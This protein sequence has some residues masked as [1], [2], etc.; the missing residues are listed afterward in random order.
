MPLPPPPPGPPPPSARSQSLSRPV[1]SPSTRIAP[2]LPGRTR[3]PPGHGT[4]LETVPPTPVDWREE[5]PNLEER[6]R[7]NSDGPMP[8]HIDTG[9]I[10]RNRR[11]GYED[12][13]PATASTNAHVRRDSSAGGL[14]RSTAV[15]NRSAKGLRE[16]RSESKNGKGRAAED[17]AADYSGSVAPWDDEG[18]D[19]RPTDLVFPS[20]NTGLGQQASPRRTPVSGK[21]LQSLDSTLYSASQRH[22]SSDTPPFDASPTPLVS[23]LSRNPS[24]FSPSTPPL[25][26]RRAREPLSGNSLHGPSRLSQ[27]SFNTSPDQPARKPMTKLTLAVP[28]KPGQRPISHILHSP[29]N[30]EIAQVPLTPST[31]AKQRPVSDLLGPESPRAFAERAMERHRIFVEREAKAPSDSERL[32]LFVEFMVVE[33]RIRRQQYTQVFEREEVDT[34]MLGKDLFRQPV[35]TTIRDIDED[36]QVSGVDASRRTSMASSALADSSSQ[37][38]SSL[39][40]KHESPSSASTSSSIP[41]SRL[42]SSWAKDYVPCLSPIASMSIVTG[43]DEMDSRGRAPSRWWEDPS[44]PGSAANDGFNVLGRSKRESKYMGVPREARNSPALFE[45]RMSGTFASHEWQTAESS[46]HPTYGMNE[47]P[48]EKCGWQG[49]LEETIVRPPQQ[50]PTPATAP[51]NP[52]VRGLDISR[53]VTLPPPYPR[54]HPAV[55]NNHPDLAD[56]RTVVRSLHEK[57]QLETIRAAFQVELADKQNRAVSWCNHQR[58]LHRQDVQYRIEHGEMTQGQYDELEIE[59]EGKV[60]KSDRDVTQAEF[61][62][63]QD[64]AVSPLHALFADRI[65]L[66]TSSLEKLS[67]RLFSSSQHHS[68]NLPQEEGDE[69]PEL[70]EK[71]TQLKWLFEAR[72]T[73]HRQT[74]E[75]LSERNEKYKAIVLLPYKQSHND[76][77]YADAEK[78]FAQDARDR[79]HAFEKASSDRAQAFLEVID[80]NVSRGVEVQLDAFWQIAPSLKEVLHKIP[81][82]LESFEIRIPA[83]EYVENPSYHDHPLQY[84][85]SLLSHAEKSTHQFIESQINLLCLLHEIR[86]CALAARCSVQANEHPTND[87]NAYRSSEE[88]RLTEDLKE[89]V[90]VVEGQWQEALAE[91]LMGVR[92]RVREKLLEDGGWDDEEEGV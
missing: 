30:D 31:L 9:S 1:E 18:V 52:E 10:L 43:Q 8:L 86:S 26:P 48:P 90:G 81:S 29:N 82:E 33:S 12:T 80:N 32:Q 62:L 65:S 50:P 70:L 79:K 83:D 59:L 51:L 74:Y 88:R 5:S 76:D 22:P 13:T 85:Y 4:S 71:L 39:S 49:D 92:E 84:L 15:R 66:A 21:A 69:Q 73:L 58:S 37:E 27:H 87:T 68:P 67:G 44:Q 56:V 64:K 41:I 57:E 38:E 2:T 42:D 11:P 40:H 47:Y 45:Q 16:R 55:N 54:H 7:E 28:P 35:A 63:F 24:Q 23:V 78:F 53:L 36:H 72:E 34:D 91:E 89:K 75:L 46:Q 60:E 6:I 19:I 3:R 25:S 77:K 17:S 14:S 61:D 20:A